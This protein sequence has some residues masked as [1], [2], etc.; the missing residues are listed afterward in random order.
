[1][2]RCEIRSVRDFVAE[3]L[4]GAFRRNFESRSRSNLEGGPCLMITNFMGLA[5]DYAIVKI[6]STN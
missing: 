6:S 4:F 3:T 1:M 2:R 5:I